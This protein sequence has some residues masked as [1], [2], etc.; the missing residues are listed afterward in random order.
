MRWIL[1]KPAYITY[2]DNAAVVQLTQQLAASKPRSRHLSTRASW[3][4]HLVKHENVSMQFVP[5]NYE[6]A[7]I[8]TKGL[9][10]YVRELAREGLRLQI[11]NAT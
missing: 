5:T 4:H 7:D 9:T 3:L 1:S 10:A 8:L 6:R 2:R 11:C